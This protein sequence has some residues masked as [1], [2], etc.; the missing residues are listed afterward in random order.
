MAKLVGVF[1]A[2]HSPFAYMPPERWNEVRA[3]R[4][5]RED[6]PME[7]L[8]TCRQKAE[9]VQKSW[10]TLRSKVTE[11]KPDV[12]VIFGDDQLECFDFNN[13][14]SFLVYVGEEFKGSLTNTDAR[15]TQGGER[16]R[17]QMQTMKGH[18][19]LAS[20]IL[21]GVMD[22][23]FDPAFA[24]DLPKPDRGIGH[25]VMRLAESLTDLKT[26]IVPVLVNC[27]FA[28]QVTG[29]R[30]YQ[31]GKAV[32]EVI[33]A[34]PGNERVALMGSGG[35]WHTPGAKDAWLD[36]DWDRGELA[37][38]EAGDIRGMAEYFDNYKIAAGDR[39][40]P[41]VG[42]AANATGLPHSPGLQGGGR[43]TANWIVAAAAVDGS[44]AAVV[45]YIPAYAS[46]CGL[47]F[48]YWPK[49]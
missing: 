9:R 34:Y 27:Y 40:Q 46:P 14:P 15:F 20:A 22:R 42:R 2:S 10:A 47:S 36:E 3:S 45:D 25:A 21:R 18:P 44:R 41:V 30:A 31:F 35:L 49:I 33:D 12:I 28:P 16:P 7:D 39:S 1:T 38:L 37:F 43:E 6:V 23:G 8:D 32:R 17:P 19:A 11:A 48:A 4:S 5:L 24:M 29:M 13:Y 26:P